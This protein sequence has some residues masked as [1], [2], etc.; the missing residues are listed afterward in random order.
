MKFEVS[1]SLL[2]EHYAST[3]VQSHTQTWTSLQYL[4]DWKTLASFYGWIGRFESY[5]VAQL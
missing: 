4:K 1:Q 3:Y 5:L 2:W